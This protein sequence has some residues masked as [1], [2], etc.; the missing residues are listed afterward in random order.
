MASPNGA[1]TDCR[2]KLKCDEENDIFFKQ[3]PAKNATLFEIYPGHEAGS[4]C[5]AGLSGK[6][7]SIGF[8]RRF[9]PMLS[10]PRDEYVSAVIADL[11]P[12][13]LEMAR[14]FEANLDGR[15]GQMARA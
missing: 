15:S 11:P 9:S 4:A 3:Q 6:P 12:Q 1:P 10:M 5:G 8:E 14:I 13:P 7:S 2:W